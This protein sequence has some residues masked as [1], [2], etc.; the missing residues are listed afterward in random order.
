MRSCHHRD[1]QRAF[2]AKIRRRYHGIGLAMENVGASRWFQVGH[3]SS[4]LPV[5]IAQ[6]R[7]EFDGLFGLVVQDFN[8]DSKADLGAISPAGFSVFY[9]DGSGGFTRRLRRIRFRQVDCQTEAQRVGELLPFR[10]V[11]TVYQIAIREPDRA[12]REIE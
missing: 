3:R 7:I 8:N 12:R 2:A 4:G 10:H 5:D 6:H 11:A 1:D 9:G